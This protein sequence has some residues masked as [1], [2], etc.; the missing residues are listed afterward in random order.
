MALAAEVDSA[1]SYGKP[2][3]ADEEYIGAPPGPPQP[4]RPD[5]DPDAITNPPRPRKGRRVD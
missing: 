1:L 4:P 3:S 5:P 2:S